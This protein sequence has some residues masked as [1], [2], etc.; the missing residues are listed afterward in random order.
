MC[1][2]KNGIIKKLR[3]LKP[4]MEISDN[5]EIPLLGIYPK[6]IKLLIL[7]YIQTVLCI[8]VIFTYSQKHKCQLKNAWTK[9]LS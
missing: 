7:K 6:D 4:K 8:I 5:T 3:H 1:D 9:N 2:Y